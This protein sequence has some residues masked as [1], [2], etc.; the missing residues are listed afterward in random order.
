MSHRNERIERPL[1]LVA[2]FISKMRELSIEKKKK[3]LEAVKTGKIHDASSLSMYQIMEDA[4]DLIDE[5]ENR[6]KESKEELAKRILPSDEDLHALIRPLIPII[7]KAVDGRDGKDGYI[8]Q[9]GKDYFDGKNGRDGKDGIVDEA[10]IVS[11][12]SAMTEERL[13]PFIPKIEDIENDLPKLGTAIRDSLELLQGDSRLDISAIKGAKEI[14]DRIAGLENKPILMASIA[15]RDIIK[16]IDLSAS[17]NGVTTTF[18]LQAIWNVISVNLSSYPY[19]SL[20]KGID[21]TWTPTTITFTNTIDPTTQ[22]S[23]GQ[24]CILTVVVS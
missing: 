10:G 4:Q 5:L 18:P 9:K 20:R 13:K 15:G 2:F 19:G 7:P 22:L 6:I 11:K 8:P 1:T 17:L 12:T 14:G 3:M 16:D 24:Q 23:A 21:Y